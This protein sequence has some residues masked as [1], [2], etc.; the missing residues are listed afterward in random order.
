MVLQSA[1]PVMAFHNIAVGRRHVRRSSPT[2][3]G[4][5]INLGE[6]GKK[7]GDATARAL[8]WAQVV[9]LVVPDFASFNGGC[10]L[11]KLDGFEPRELP[12]LRRAL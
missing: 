8:S 3:S 11:K 4:D 7:N 2:T 12:E 10:G 9:S 5:S 1:S 6:H